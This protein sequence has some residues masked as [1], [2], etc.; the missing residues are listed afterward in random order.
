MSSSY[1]PQQAAAVRKAIAYARAALQEAGRYDPL[2]FARAF[3]DSGGVQIPGH[4]EDSERAQH[5]AR[6]T[7]AVLAGAENADDDDVLREAHRA[8]V[9]TR[10]AQ[11]AREDGVVGFFLRL[12]PRAAADPRCRTLLDVDYGLGAGVIPKTHILVPP[13]CCRDYDYVPVRDHE[14]EQ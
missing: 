7:L 6:A 5:I 4:G 13:P 3:I 2:D 12:G 11:A 1:T 9:E 10:W 8:R 14:V